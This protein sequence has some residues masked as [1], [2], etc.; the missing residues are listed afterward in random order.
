MFIDKS[1]RRQGGSYIKENGR[2]VKQ[3]PEDKTSVKTLPAETKNET[4]AGKPK[5][6]ET[7]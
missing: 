6:K 3:T 5:T 2:L 7:K 4:P 1:K